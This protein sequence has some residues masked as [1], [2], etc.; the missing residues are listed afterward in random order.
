MI[1]GINVGGT[2]CSALVADKDGQVAERFAWPAHSE[3]GPQAMIK[4]IVSALRSM[5]AK[6][7]NIERIGIAI[8]GPMTGPAGVIESPPHLPGWD[9]LD[10]GAVLR[11]TFDLP[12]RIEHDAA[13]CAFAEYLWGTFAGAHGLVYL[14][15]GTGSGAGV[16]IG[17]RVIRGT[18][19]AS[20]EVGHSRL[21]YVGPK[22]W[23]KVGSV[24]AYCSASSLALLAAWRFPDRW[25]S[26]ALP[27]PSEITSL[28]VKGDPEAREVLRISACGVGQLCANIADFLAPDVILLG[29]LARY[30]GEPWLRVVCDTFS[31]EVHPRLQSR[32]RVAP[33]TLGEA[34]QDLSGIAAAL[35]PD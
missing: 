21:A 22:V 9:N 28:A 3:R 4:E 32:T 15:C 11:K 18:G 27:D 14:T 34:V 29:S 17:G 16:V 33:A 8:G 10:L 19:G 26:E 35:T 5:L 20:C 12:V 13:A 24:E 1:A 30:V 2:T 6:H 23:G 31:E 25:D 7:G